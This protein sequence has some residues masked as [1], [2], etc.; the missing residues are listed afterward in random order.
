MRVDPISDQFPW[1]STFNYAENEPVANIDLHGLQKFNT[2]QYDYNRARMTSEEKKVFLQAQANALIEVADALVDELPL[3]GEV[4]AALEGDATGVLMAALFP[5]GRKLKKAADATK[6]RVYLRKSTKEKI[7]ENAPKT[8]DGNFI[9]P[10]TGKIIPKEGSFDY[11]HKTGQ[12]WHRRKKM[13]KEKGS[14]RK[15]VR[16]T[17]N[18]PDLYQIEDPS[19]N[20]SHRFEKKKGKNKNR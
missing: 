5:G 16:D 12:E 18:N 2:T 14:T 17:E 4:R 15:E 10:N 6:R 20:R 9:D 11:G 1:V 3:V 13:H 8:S 7:K 19:S